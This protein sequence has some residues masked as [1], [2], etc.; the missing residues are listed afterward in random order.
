M[1]D[2]AEI[3]IKA[4]D[5]GKGAVDFA[6]RKGK[7]F[8]PPNGGDGGKG[9][10]VYAVASP[11]QATLVDFR[12]KKEYQAETGKAGGSNQKTGEDG[13]D[14]YIEV[15]KATIIIDPVSNL[16][17]VDMANTTEPVLLAQGGDGGRGNARM[18]KAG[19]HARGPIEW[20][21]WSQADPGK[22]GEERAVRLELKL[23]ADI[24]LIGLPNAGKS[25]LLSVLTS[26]KP[27]IADYPFT[28]LEPN[29]GVAHMDKKTAI[30]A[31]IP[32]LIEGASEGK[33]LGKEFLRHIERTRVLVHLTQ[34]YQDYQTIRKELEAYGHCL[35][36]KPEIVALS[37]TDILEQTEIVEKI[38]DFSRHQ[39]R[40]IPIS[41]ATHS[42]LEELLREIEKHLE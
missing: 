27:K 3:F 35:I 38:E 41:A 23:I 12:Y 37:K 7:T 10:D 8:G 9:G 24:G 6:H 21:R 32:G 18:R 36:D 15:P 14:L 5:G 11:N 25:T 31:D 19:S 16:P 39:I 40:L 2:Y 33:G 34:D 42:G 26:A 30:I 4:G 29:L 28:T 13:K 1:I 20:E 17:V 22:P